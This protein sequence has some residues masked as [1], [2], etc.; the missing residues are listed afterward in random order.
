MYLKPKPMK[1]RVFRVSGT[2]KPSKT[3][4]AR[5]YRI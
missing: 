3:V 4:K 5:V 2:L 1:A